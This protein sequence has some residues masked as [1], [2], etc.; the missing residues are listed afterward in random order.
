MSVIVFNIVDRSRSQQP[1][2]LACFMVNNH[3]KL[4]SI[5]MIKTYNYNK[6]VTTQADSHFLYKLSKQAC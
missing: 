2:I 6:K 3:Y 5:S 1:Y 4:S